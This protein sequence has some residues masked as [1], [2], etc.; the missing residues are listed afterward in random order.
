MQPRLNNQCIV[1]QEGIVVAV[2]KFLGDPRLAQRSFD[3]ALHA[4][5]SCLEQKQIRLPYYIGD[6]ERIECTLECAYAAHGEQVAPAMRKPRKRQ[7]RIPEDLDDGKQTL[8]STHSIKQAQ[9]I[10]HNLLASL[11]SRPP[12]LL[13]NQSAQ[14]VMDE[15]LRQHSP[16]LVPIQWKHLC[17]PSCRRFSASPHKRS[18]VYE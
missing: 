8:D 14:N 6:R 10:G 4:E 15:E 3:I 13:D 5:D 7:L 18:N 2:R 9:C 17:E 11:E 12:Q 16:T 1:R